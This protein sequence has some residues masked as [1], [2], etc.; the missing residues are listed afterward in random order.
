MSSSW[1]PL[2]IDCATS[3]AIA[4]LS[5][6]ARCCWLALR[7]AHQAKGTGGVV[8]AA[9]AFARALPLVAAAIVAGIDVA[10]GLAELAHVGLTAAHDDGLRLVDWAPE[11]E[12]SLCSS[13]R[14]RNPDPRH[15]RCPACRHRDTDPTRRGKR[16]GADVAQTCAD[17]HDSAN[18]VDRQGLALVD[19]QVAQTWRRLGAD[20]A[21]P[22]PDQTIPVP[23]HPGSPSRVAVP[24]HPTQTPAR[25]A[26]EPA[27]PAAG[28]P[29]APEPE[30][31]TVAR[32]DPSTLD[33]R[34]APIGA[35]GA[36]DEPGGPDPAAAR[37]A[38]ERWVAQIA[39]HGVERLTGRHLLDVAGLLDQIG[40]RLRIEGDHAVA[41]DRRA[42]LRNSRIELARRVIAWCPSP[43]RL[44]R[45]LCRV[46][47]WFRVRNLGAYLRR[48]AQR[49][50]PG[51][52]LEGR[53][54]RVA[55]RRAE[56]WR[57]FALATERA[58]EGEHAADVAVIVA[59][60]AAVLGEVDEA[61]R[62]R[63]R[64][65][66]R[67][68]LQAG[69]AAAAKATLLRLVPRIAETTDDRLR[70]ALRGACTVAIARELLA[71]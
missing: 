71:A 35:P 41:R 7:I 8:P 20:R 36:D 38:I 46:S 9:Y 13:C 60:T 57:D 40:P 45:W 15:G 43:E 32:P 2:P 31:V 17:D 70:E 24:A 18:D 10:A 55:G 26:G 63:L 19:D 62:D 22:R 51:T 67:E 28:A 42:A 1:L 25:P 58:L 56:T 68:H 69:R 34:S 47:R 66:L 23:E 53:T 11:V 39:R 54:R 64:A 49:G 33:A 48:A 5:P 4:T 21:R 59:G 12:A 52:V 27:S 50:D 37:A 65:E 61:A 3:V 44:G 14:R 30:P 29:A 6:E 16:P